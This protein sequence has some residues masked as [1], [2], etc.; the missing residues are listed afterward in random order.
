MIDFLVLITVSIVIAATPMLFAAI[1]ELV[2]ERSGVLNLGVEGMM[3]IGAVVGFAVTM[4]TGS[5]ILGIGSAALAGAALALI[6]AVLV[7][8]LM[9]NQVA[10]GL[11]LTIFGV[12]LSALIG[13][14]FV[15]MPIAGL[16][17]LNIPGL[18]TLPIIGPL[19]FQY[20]AMVYL[21]IA[22]TFARRLVPEAHPC[23]NGAPRRRRVGR[24]RPLHRPSRDRSPL[25]R[26]PVRRRHGRLGRRLP[27]PAVTPMWAENMTSG[28]GWI[29]LALVVF[30]S[31][32]PGR[33]LLGAY[34]FGGVT[35]L[36]LHAQGS[37]STIGL[38][39]QVFTMLPYLATIAVLTIISAGPWRGRFQAPACLG[40]SFRP[41][42]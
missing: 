40:Q 19:F 31:W 12:G 41:S 29:A 42:V 15:G 30:G 4:S 10:T 35:I 2:V 21:S 5:A 23:R 18:S 16:P 37:G 33:V 39:S 3:L 34:I 9:A 11:A 14:S 7:L 38:P 13:A 1:G 27:V 6:F 26:D 28:R 24:I 36:Q 32:R 8:T 20:D 25:S 22:L 17:K